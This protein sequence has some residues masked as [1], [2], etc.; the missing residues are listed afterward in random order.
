MNINVHAL[1][2]FWN[3][4]ELC[5]GIGSTPTEKSIKLLT[6][7]FFELLRNLCTPQLEKKIIIIS[8]L[9]LN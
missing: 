1:N 7:T 5:R 9:L 6:K 3:P 8:D 2:N 4:D